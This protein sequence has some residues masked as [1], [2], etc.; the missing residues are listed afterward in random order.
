MGLSGVREC[1]GGC[2]E[3]RPDGWLDWRGE[4]RSRCLGYP[5]CRGPTVERF[6]GH[7]FTKKEQICQK[8]RALRVFYGFSFPEVL[9][10]FSFNQTWFAGFRSQ[11]PF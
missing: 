7:D 9:V 8:V 5:D 2:P 1:P 10:S 11:F 6:R 3:R 4:R